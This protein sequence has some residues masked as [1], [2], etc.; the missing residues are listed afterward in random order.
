MS[1]PVAFFFG[2]VLGAIT[3]ALAILVAAYAGGGLQ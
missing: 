1:Q 2:A 3:S